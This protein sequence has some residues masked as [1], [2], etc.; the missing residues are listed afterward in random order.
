VTERVP[1]AET[2]A[3]VRRLVNGYQVSQAIHVLVRL[4]IPDRLASGPRSAADLAREAGAHE[5]SVYRLLRA[6]AAIRV[7][8]ELPDHQ[9]ALTELGE[10]LRT[11]VAGSVAGW[12]EFVGRPYEWRVWARV[13]DGI[14]SGDHAFRLEHGKSVWEYRQQHREELA[15]FNRAMNSL[16]GAISP[17]VVAGYD[18]SKAAK[19]VDVGGGGGLLLTEILKANPG[20]HGILFDLPDTVDDARA[21]V[22]DSGVG[23]RCELVP[24]DFFKAVPAGADL[25][26]LKSILHD[27][28]DED[29]A[30][31]LMTVRA[32]ARPDSVL[33]VIEQVIAGPNEGAIGKF[34]DLNMMIAAGGRER[35]R[36]EWEDLFKN[37]G[38]VLDEVRPSGP[39]SMLV[40]RPAL[41]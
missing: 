13:Y 38:W 9:F 41:R 21:F 27:W 15:I 18:F 40:T 14:K 8:D 1:S 4:G 36:E 39:T 30:R 12:A 22:A 31:I 32:A 28:Y 23:N 17:G 16:T 37:T 11:D 33:L 26:L 10:A 35:T 3:T 2:I 20:L 34:G 7:L 6:L 24:G 5:P 19:V 29:S 25:Y